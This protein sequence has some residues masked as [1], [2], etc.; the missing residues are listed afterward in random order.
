MTDPGFF[1][2]SSNS[3]PR[4]LGRMA[5]VLRDDPLPPLEWERI[6][7]QSGG[8][9]RWVTLELAKELGIAAS[10]GMPFPRNCA[11]WLAR[12]LL[13]STEE[14]EG[15][16]FNR[17]PLT[18]RLMALLGEELPGGD[19]APVRAYLA[20]NDM[21]KRYQLAAKIAG[22]FDEYQLY[23]T[24]LLRDWDLEDEDAAT[25]RHLGW[26][27][28]LWQR[29]CNDLEGHQHLGDRF[30][31]LISHINKLDKPADEIEGMPRRL[32]VFGVSSLPPIFIELLAALGRHIPVTVYR[33]SPTRVKKTR[34]DGA[35]DEGSLEGN[36]LLGSMG[37]QG[38][39]FLELLL[40]HGAVEEEAGR[41]PGEDAQPEE[42]SG[43]DQT[44]K[45]KPEGLWVV[46]GGVVDARG[47]TGDGGPGGAEGGDSDTRTLLQVIQND[48][49]D[50][51]DRGGF[52][53]WSAMAGGPGDPEGCENAEDLASGSSAASAVSPGS[54]DAPP[55]ALDPGDRSLTVHNCHSPL[56]EMEVLRDLLLQAFD[57]TPDLKPGDILV[58]MPAVQDYAPYIDAVFGVKHDDTPHIPY[59]IADKRRGEEQPL[60]EG[61][62]KVLALADAR[63]TATEVIDLLEIPS[64]RRKAG[65]L[66]SE[67]PQVR[68][69]VRE[70]NI[71]WGVDGTFKQDVFNLPPFEANTW[72]AGLD[73]LLMGMITGPRDDL[74]A[75][76][77]PLGTA[78]MNHLDLL[79]RFDCWVV[80]LFQRLDAMRTPQSLTGWAELLGDLLE[81][82]FAPE[83]D[84]EQA[85]Q[86]VR[87]EL[88]RLRRAGTEDTDEQG[89]SRTGEADG[90]EPGGSGHG[91]VN[92]RERSESADA[93]ESEGSSAADGARTIRGGADSLQLDVAVIRD[94]L[95]QALGEEGRASSFISGAVTFCALKPMRTIPFKVIAVAGLDDGS[96]PSKERPPTFDLMAASPVKGDRSVRK[97]QKQLF[98]ETL[99]AAQD[100]LII[101]YVGRSQKDNKE[102]AASVVVDELLNVVGQSFVS[103]ELSLR[104][105]PQGRRSNLS[106]PR[107]AITTLH[108]LQPFNAAYFDRSEDKL[109]SYSR[110]NCLAAEGVRATRAAQEPPEAIPFFTEPIPLDEENAE[111]LTLT[112]DELIACWTHPCKFFCNKTLG[113][114]LPREE[115]E[116]EDVEPLEMAGLEKYAFENWLADERLKLAAGRGPGE[117]IPQPNMKHEW[118]ILEAMGDLPPDHLGRAYHAQLGTQVQ[119][120]VEKVG[121]PALLE[122][123]TVDLEGEVGGH[124]WKLTGRI[125]SL[126]DLGRVQFRC[127]TLKPKDIIRAWVTHVV[128]NVDTPVSSRLV[129]RDKDRTFDKLIDA[130]EVLDELLRGFRDALQRPLPFFEK[131]SF[132]FFN[133]LQKIREYEKTGKGRKPQPLWQAAYGKWQGDQ[134]HG[135]AAP[136]E[137]DD[138]YIALCFRDS[139]PL[140]DLKEGFEERARSFWGLVDENSS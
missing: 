25:Y 10:I 98:L 20:D 139:E 27:S 34:G 72:R 2:E 50:D 44:A 26:Q 89:E 105:A 65:I 93:N 39:V 74:V 23:R 35:G 134:F 118:D 76:I 18:W 140:V 29:I 55:L 101:S 1:I 107:D 24:E 119:Q 102:R 132:A 124:P 5:G 126:T 128:L 22:T 19:F 69:W 66:G 61:V 58:M 84:E 136:G 17:Q 9:R 8:M 97:D 115:A 51:V 62:L 15:D 138:Q 91:D 81:H 129:A 87:E 13:G 113:I 60:S 46:H 121:A 103:P 31:D 80:D 112:L 99:A 45:T 82:F 54:A 88:N 16:P 85:L 68:H 137:R 75:G 120:F 56:R 130:R 12:K 57:S 131:T 38:D 41:A 28:K 64:V 104:G 100:R 48:I 30:R 40:K 53:S 63:L 3:L 77:L 96:F 47:N 86:T 59:S 125:E 36:R 116:L 127:A 32:S 122:P 71:R 67:L 95:E 123:M 114:V 4:L 108:P 21:R 11:S 7:V 6:V 70:T 135:G 90:E 43:N 52:G 117:P 92:A 94:H 83:G 14:D 106:S 49:L 133:S 110:Q 73:R 37:E 33:F 79:G 42:A 111:C 109:F 78:T